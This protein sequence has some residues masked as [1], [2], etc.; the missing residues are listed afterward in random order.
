MFV[1]IEEIFLTKDSVLACSSL[2]KDLLCLDE[3]AFRS[4]F[5]LM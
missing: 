2:I 5:T 4:R 1:F 3:K